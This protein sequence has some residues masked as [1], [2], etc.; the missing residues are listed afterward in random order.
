M[1]RFDVWLWMVVLGGSP[2]AGQV[3]ITTPAGVLSNPGSTLVSDPPALDTW[4]RR[5]VRS[6]GSVGITAAYPRAGNAS[7]W[8]SLG[9]NP[10]NQG[11]ADWEYVPST[12]FGRLADLGVVQYDWYRDSASVVSNWLHPAFRLIVDADGNTTTTNDI[13]YLIYERCYNVSGC[14]PAPTNTWVTDSIT[15]ST[16]L[17]LWWIGVGTDYVFN[18]TLS[19]YQSGSYASTPGFPVLNGSSLVLGVSLGVGSAW[20]GSSPS[21]VGG[22]DL[23][24]VSSNTPGAA[25]IFHNFEVAAD[26]AANGGSVPP[27]LGPGASYNLSYSCTSNGPG[28]A[29]NAT[30]GV[31]VSAG[32]VSGVSCSPPTPVPLLPPSNT[33]SCTY[34]FTAPGS[35]GGGDTPETGVTFSFTAAAA[36]DTDPSNDTV[37]SSVTPTPLVDA[38][39]DTASFPANTVGATFNVG[40]ND[41]YGTGSLPA[42]ASFSLQAGTTCPSASINAT[43]GVATFNVPAAGTCVVAYRVCAISGC[44]TAQLTVSAQQAEP[45][46][47]LEE[48]GLWALATLMAASGVVLLRRLRV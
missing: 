45:I 6:D 2:V 32:T 47:T 9:T 12:S 42:G 48:W 21:F 36:H 20:P 40:T 29:V 43:T 44:D 5:N 33:I 46:P 28:D 24:R 17:W 3:V 10:S 27:S 19:D 26:L 41:Q 13:V 16:V 30:C 8:F 11:K 14:P 23:V 25:S 38:L 35:T 39:D 1:K 37:T 15:G 34:T 4:M 22:V 31:S 18:R 7:V